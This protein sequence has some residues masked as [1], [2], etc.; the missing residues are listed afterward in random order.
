MNKLKAKK[1]PLTKVEDTMALKWAR[2]INRGEEQRYTEKVKAL[3][4]AMARSCLEVDREK[5]TLLKFKEKVQ[6]STGHL[7]E[8][9]PRVHMKKN[10]LPK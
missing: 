7:S 2:T 10:C 8:D 9:C 3:Q 4:K 6:R 5:A 1:M